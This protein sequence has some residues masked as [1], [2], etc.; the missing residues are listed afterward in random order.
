MSLRSKLVAL[1]P[2]LLLLGAEAAAQRGGPPRRLVDPETIQLPSGARVE[3]HTF[4]S[5]SLG[6]ALGYSVFLPAGYDSSDRNYPVV[7]F[8]HGMN[9]DHT[10]WCVGRYGN[11]PE[12]VDQT[13][14]DHS[15]AE[16]VMAHPS[17]ES[18][19]YTDSADGQALYES[20]FQN[21]FIKEIENR[22]RVRKDRE[23]R[24]IGGTSMGGYG[25]LKMAFK[26]SDSYAAVAASSPIVLLGDDPS[27]LLNGSDPRRS[28]FFSRLLHRVYGDPV[29][30]EHW[31][32]NNLKNLAAA[33]DM[34]SLRVMMLYGTADRYNRMIPME[35]GVRR[36][37][38][39]LEARTVDHE[40]HIY[41]GEPHGWELVGNHLPEIL[42]FLAGSF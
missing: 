3:F 22:F 11:L 18:G 36:L 12:I 21:D 35:D 41:E 30:L 19:Y 34:N 37:A 2:A 8:L 24:A 25:A 38:D 40:L 23:G 14:R 26:Y 15:L 20:A 28:Q 39:L 27:E 29:D 16:F 33:G 17:G 10:S 9:N 6:R 13:I 5:G 1:V 4:H 42:K 7:F 31:K 32:A